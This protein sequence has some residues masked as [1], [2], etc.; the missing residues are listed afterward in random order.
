MR[1]RG[2]DPGDVGRPGHRRQGWG[3][4]PEVSQP[5]PG[6][7]GPRP[8]PGPVAA[9]GREDRRRPRRSCFP[10]CDNIATELCGSSGKSELNLRWF[11]I[12]RRRSLRVGC[13]RGMVGLRK[14]GACGHA[15]QSL[16]ELSFPFWKH[17]LFLYPHCAALQRHRQQVFVS[18][19]FRELTDGGGAVT[20]RRRRKST[21]RSCTEFRDGESIHRGSAHEMAF[22]RSR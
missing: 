7:A 8:V 13:F 2:G 18:A 4:C 21:H 22:E 6:G 20:G 9:Q 12:T 11:R 15:L 3:Q 10:K 16:D 14:S 1:R 19:C 5:A 17:M